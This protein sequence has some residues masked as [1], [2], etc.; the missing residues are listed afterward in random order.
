VRG[1]R[2][3]RRRCGSVAPAFAPVAAL[4]VGL[5]ARHRGPARLTVSSRLAPQ[6]MMPVGARGFSLIESDGK[7]EAG[8]QKFKITDLSGIQ[9]ACLRG[10]AYMRPTKDNQIDSQLTMQGIPR[11]GSSFAS[12]CTLRTARLPAGPH[13]R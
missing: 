11:T 2:D 5:R 13:A 3:E 12:T 9:G 8:E 6:P 1:A 4:H 10:N 7:D